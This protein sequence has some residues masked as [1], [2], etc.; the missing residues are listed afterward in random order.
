MATVLTQAESQRLTEIVDAWIK[1]MAGKSALDLIE[2]KRSPLVEE[3]W[4]AAR[5]YTPR[6]S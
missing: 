5:E 2:L 3:V 1:E 6:E 4:V